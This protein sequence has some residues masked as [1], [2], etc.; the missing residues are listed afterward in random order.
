MSDE[1]RGFC[2]GGTAAVRAQLEAIVGVPCLAAFPTEASPADIVFLSVSATRDD[3]AELPGGNA[4]AACRDLKDRFG[5]R[6]YLLI[7]PG[8]EISAEIGRFCLADG[9]LEADASRLVSEPPVIEDRLS[10][11]RPRVSLNALLARLE[12]EIASDEGR[13]VSALQRMLQEGDSPSLL[14]SLV[15]PETGL[16]DGPYMSLKLDEEFKRSMR[17]HQPLS[18]LLLDVG[19]DLDAAFDDDDAR[20]DFLAEVASVFLIECRDIDVIGR[21]TESVFMIMMPGTGSAGAGFVVRRML[22]GI[23]AKVVLATVSGSPSC[24]MATMPAAGIQTRQAFLARAEACL[25]RARQ[26]EGQEG[27]CASSE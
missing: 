23:R 21:F 2:I 22:D 3:C 14:H 10:P 25:Q 9:S 24:G 11:H 4:F 26:G 6:V 8:D 1:V 12:A 19:V 7:E 5:V 16:F 13:R 27:F 17:F 18:L 15:D 20:R